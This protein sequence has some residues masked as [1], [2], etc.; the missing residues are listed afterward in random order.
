MMQFR[1]PIYDLALLGASLLMLSCGEL[2]VDPASPM[3]M[4]DSGRPMVEDQFNRPERDASPPVVQGPDIVVATFNVRKFFDTNCDTRNCNDNSFESEPTE[5]EFLAKAQTVA[6][7][8]RA[9]NADIV[10]LQEFETEECLTATMSFLGDMNYTVS[11]ISET[12][13][14][15]SLDVVVMGRGELAGQRSH[16][17]DEIPLPNRGTTTFSR[18]FLEVHILYEGYRIIAFNGHFKA[19]TRDDPQRRLAEAMAA[20]EIAS[21]VATNYPEAL[22]VLGGDLNDTPGSAPINALES[23]G[24]FLRVASELG[25]EAATYTYRGEPQAIDHLY[26]VQTPGGQYLPGSARVIRSNS[27]GLAGSDHAALVAAFRWLSQ[28]Q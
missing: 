4:T 6:N 2:P 18:D 14:N 20:H 1:P 17:N 21:E 23:G 24:Q 15:A 16:G 26:L 12:G 11:L 8:I 22:V 19:K 27:R 25:S 28:G 3:Y 10:L 9:L 7:G 5:A 13:G